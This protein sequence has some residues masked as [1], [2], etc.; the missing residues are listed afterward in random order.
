[1]FISH[2]DVLL[3]GTYSWTIPFPLM[4]YLSDLEGWNHIFTEVLCQICEGMYVK[5]LSHVRLFATPWTVAHQA[6]LH[7]GFSRQEYWSGLPF[8]IFFYPDLPFYS[9]Y[10]IF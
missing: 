5:S 2:L 4:D 6:P 10:C 3:G 9:P 8:N 1:M 7:M